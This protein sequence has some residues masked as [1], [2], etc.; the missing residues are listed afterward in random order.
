MVKDEAS[1]HTHLFKNN[2]LKS[3]IC[4]GWTEPFRAAVHSVTVNLSHSV[5]VNLYCTLSSLSLHSCYTAEN[6]CCYLQ[7]FVHLWK[8]KQFLQGIRNKQVRVEMEIRHL[9]KLVV[10]ILCCE[11]LY[12]VT[13]TDGDKSL[14]RQDRDSK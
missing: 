1:S 10:V 9:S 5:N 11:N 13:W 6:S 3:Q 12:R 8:K 14:K 2:S 4:K 7:S